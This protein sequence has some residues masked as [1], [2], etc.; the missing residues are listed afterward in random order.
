MTPH[1][2]RRQDFATGGPKVIRG[3]HSLNT[4]MDVCSNR[5]PIM[6]SEGTDLKWG[7]GGQEPL[8]PPAGDGPAPHS[9]MS[10]DNT[11]STILQQNRH[12]ESL[13]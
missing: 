3:A 2:A 10:L 4:I 1:Q 12:Q 6:K 11:F 9:F 7:A 5:A 8:A 13:N